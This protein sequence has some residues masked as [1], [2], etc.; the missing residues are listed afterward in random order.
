MAVILM[1]P[2]MARA[3]ECSIGQ[4]THNVA[5]VSETTGAQ[6]ERLLGPPQ[7]TMALRSASHMT[8]DEAAWWECTLLRLRGGVNVL[9]AWDPVRA[10]PRGSLRGTPT[11]LDAQRGGAGVTLGGITPGQTLAMGDWLQIGGGFTTS[12]LVK[13]VQPATAGG[14][15]QMGVYIEP[16]IRQAIATGSPATVERALGYYRVQGSLRS[17]YQAGGKYKQGGFALD[18]VETWR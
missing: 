10:I 1:P 5:E 9:A 18:L 13:V 11:V 8:L 4:I 7:W 17:A 14:D 2:A 6:S 3:V 16:P 12:Q 15:G